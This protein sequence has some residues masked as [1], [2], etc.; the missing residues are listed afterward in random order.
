MERNINREVY[1][2]HNFP[3]LEKLNHWNRKIFYTRVYNLV[4]P[5]GVEPAFAT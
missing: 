2:S 1:T 3:R 5:A 4:I